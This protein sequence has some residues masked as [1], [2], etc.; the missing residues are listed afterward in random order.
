MSKI[1][2]RSCQL[3]SRIYDNVCLLGKILCLL[4]GEITDSEKDEI[5]KRFEKHE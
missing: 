1:I 4:D 3:D 2:K 5:K